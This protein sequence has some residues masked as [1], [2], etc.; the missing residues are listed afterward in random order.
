MDTLLLDPLKWDLQLTA[1]GDIGLTPRPYA[2]AQDVAT[3]CRT[4]LGEVWYDTR[5]GI[6]YD[7]SILGERP[8]LQFVRRQMEQVALTVPNVAK[9]R[10]LF[11]T[12]DGRVLT[13]QIQIIDNEGVTS[14]VQF[15]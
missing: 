15:Q 11:A 9:A 6:P 1:S 13:G 4:F 8:S 3:A 2:T 14:N 7:T 5:Q 12:F 10:C